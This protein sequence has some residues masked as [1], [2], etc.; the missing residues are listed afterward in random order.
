MA[1]AKRP[2]SPA[3][4]ALFVF[5]SVPIVVALGGLLT[6]IIAC[7]SIVL[8]RPVPEDGIGLGEAAIPQADVKLY[9]Q[10]A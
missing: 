9:L 3:A 1:T 8:A 5:I 10:I 4:T 2:L 7:I 6:R